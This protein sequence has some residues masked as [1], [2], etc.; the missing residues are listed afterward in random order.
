MDNDC[1]SECEYNFT[2]DKKSTLFSKNKVDSITE[3]EAFIKL[4][5]NKWIDSK[6]P[7]LAD[8]IPR[9]V[10]QTDEGKQE[11]LKLFPPDQIPPY[12]PIE[13]LLKKLNI[14][15]NNRYKGREDYEIVGSKYLNLFISEEWNELFKITRLSL[16]N[17]FSPE[18]SEG[19][20]HEKVT[21]KFKTFTIVASALSENRNEA[22][23]Q[24]D[25]NNKYDFTLHLVFTLG[26][27]FVSSRIMGDMK[28]FYSEGDA[29]KILASY[30]SAEELGNAFDFLKEYNRIYLDSPD[31]SYYWGV[32]YTLSGKNE[33]AKKHYL[34]ALYLEK[35]FV[36]ARYNY[37]FILQAENDLDGAE[38]MYKELLEIEPKEA[39]TLNNLAVISIGRN[40]FNTAEKYLNSC[41][42]YFP[43]FELARKNIELIKSLKDT[44]KD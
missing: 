33:Q 38:K 40:D 6:A 20:K 36:N 21:A 19:F 42:K 44:N 11:I 3:Q 26:R 2:K 10:A 23:V 13:Y 43:D 34:Q 7:E 9:T 15:M 37:A 4:Q 41:L 39:K 25:V 12:M 16:E 17:D 27:W 1:P 35:K 14:E 32:Y 29:V 18:F 31:V 24:F 28:L 30:L 8:R 5:M 22:L